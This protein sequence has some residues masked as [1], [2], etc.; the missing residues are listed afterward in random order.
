VLATPL[1]KADDRAA[2]WK[3]G[4]ELGRRLNEETAQLDRDEDERREATPAPADADT[5]R[6]EQQGYEAAARRARA[7]VALLQLGGL[8]AAQGRAGEGAGAGGAGAKARRAA[9]AARGAALRQAFTDRLRAQLALSTDP[10]E[11]ERIGRI[12]PPFDTA[13]VLDEAALPPAARL[14]QRDEM[15][16]WAWLGD[17]CRYEGR[18]FTAAGLDAAT[19][20]PPGRFLTQAAGAFLA[21]AGPPPD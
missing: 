14:R 19:G 5:A 9:W 21:V 17:R 18:D 1:L 11:Q 6:L 2:L 3:A 20:A 12:F 13:R 8:P 15:A 4:R 10:A 16:L 7:A